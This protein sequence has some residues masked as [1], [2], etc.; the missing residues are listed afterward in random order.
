MTQSPGMEAPFTFASRM[1]RGYNVNE[2]NSFYATAVHDNG[3]LNDEVT[4]LRKENSKLL[5]DG[6]SMAQ[7]LKAKED[8][9]RVLSLSGDEL[10]SEVANKSA[11]LRVQN[12][13]KRSSEMVDEAAKT[14]HQIVSEAEKD[15]SQER[16]AALKLREEAELEV[17]SFRRSADMEIDRDYA[18][19]MKEVEE[20]RANFRSWE[21]KETA[22]ITELEKKSKDRCVSEEDRA[23]R[24]AQETVKN[25]EAEAAQL[26][27]TARANIAS[28]EKN[29][30]KEI[31]A[32]KRK[33]YEQIDSINTS[34]RGV[35]TISE[36]LE[37]SNKELA[38][39]KKQ[40]N[41]AHE[42]WGNIVKDSLALLNDETSS[43][44]IVDLDDEI[45]LAAVSEQ[46]PSV[47]KDDHLAE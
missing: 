31:S 29:A 27:R 41:N 40:M 15:A 12:A 16:A 36:S 18:D 5:H 1:E 13:Q 6:G 3:V 23:R 25:A 30:H 14:A 42:E 33:A 35:K 39:T 44:Q 43:I 34:L 17:A 4:K 26:I 7:Q 24:A 28:E 10:T 22:K 2:V 45:A 9:I 37:R 21:S 32:A 19:K 20:K 38:E 46:V 11:L 8:D 47:Y